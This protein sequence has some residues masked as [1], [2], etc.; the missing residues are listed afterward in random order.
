M[1]GEVHNIAKRVA[2]K[3]R[4]MAERE[5]FREA[6]RLR[7]HAEETEWKSR[8]CA[9]AYWAYGIAFR[10]NANARWNATRKRN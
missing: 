4:Q 10:V 1:N 7:Q 8:A 6:A 9:V 3:Q 5:A 2:I